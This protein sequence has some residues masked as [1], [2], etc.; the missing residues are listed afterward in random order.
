MSSSSIEPVPRGSSGLPL[1]FGWVRLVNPKTL[2]LVTLKAHRG[3]F[4]EATTEWR[5]A[6]ADV[7]PEQALAVHADDL[8]DRG[9][10]VVASDAAVF[11]RSDRADRNLHGRQ[12]FNEATC[13]SLS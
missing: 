9:C 3:G 12:W 5:F 2:Q 6:P 7:L 8:M 1:S 4:S 11:G 13:E 10:R